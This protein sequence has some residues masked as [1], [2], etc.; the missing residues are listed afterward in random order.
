[1]VFINTIEDL[2]M[3]ESENFIMNRYKMFLLSFFFLDYFTLD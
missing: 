3:I 1:M 2:I